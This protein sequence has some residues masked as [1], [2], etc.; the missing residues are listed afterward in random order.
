V[1]HDFRIAARLHAFRTRSQ[2]WYRVAHRIARGAT[3]LGPA[4]SAEWAA[5][6]LLHRGAERGTTSSS[7]TWVTAAEDGASTT[8]WVHNYWSD[9]YGISDHLRFQATLIRPDGG[10]TAA[11]SFDLAPD[12]TD[13]IDIRDRCQAAGVSLPF[14]G[15]LLLALTHPKLVGSRPLQVFADYATDAGQITGV[16]GQYGLQTLPAAQEV[17]EMRLEAGPDAR[18]GV[19]LINAYAGPGRPRAMRSTLKIHDADGRARQRRLP[20]LAANSSR[21][22]WIDEAFPD[23]ADFLGGRPGSVAVDLPCP[24]SRLATFI[25][26]DGGSRRVANHGTVNTRWSQR[27]GR[28]ADWASESVASAFALCDEHRD[29]LLTLINHWG[30]TAGPYS[31]TLRL[32]DEAGQEIGARQV[33]IP[34]NGTASVST[35]EI[36]TA[37]GRALPVIAHAQV[38]LRPVRPVD[39][40]PAIFNVLAGLV[41][42]GRL[43]GEVLFGA[44]FLNGDVPPG[45]GLPDVRRTRVFARVNIRGGTQT[46]VFLANPSAAAG[47]DTVAHATLTLLDTD[48]GKRTTRQV[49]LRPHGCALFDVGTLFPE[50]A[51]ALAPTGTGTLRVRS[52]DARLIGAHFVN[53]PGSTTVAVDHLVGG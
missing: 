15:Q 37:A 7:F 34:V 46:A 35:R 49:E 13:A 19:V 40:L 43:V 8:V 21:V 1:R 31:A 33:V 22:V 47:Y 44:T 45:T 9:A 36:V 27:P 23:V 17:G 28:P 29:T 38:T 12:A 11:W 42:D 39:E 26:F 5:A 53:R 30:P 25:D 20:R 41:D 51:Q 10:I 50:G 24:T 4:A 32:W 6:R 18:T 3:G 16:H 14:E 2:R 48:G 52:T